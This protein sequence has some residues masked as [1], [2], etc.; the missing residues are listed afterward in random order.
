[1]TGIDGPVIRPLHL[2]TPA[3]EG[4]L[5]DVF[6]AFDEEFFVDWQVADAGPLVPEKPLLVR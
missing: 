4:P 2:R 3:L 5:P 6:T 1:L